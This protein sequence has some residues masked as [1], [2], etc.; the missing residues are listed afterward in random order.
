[1]SRPL[2]P[3]GGF[4]AFEA[5]ARHLSFARA[6]EELRV[7]PAAISHQVRTLEDYLGVALFRRS[8]R[9]VLLTEAGQIMLPDL[10]RSFDLM[11]AAM[12]QAKRLAAGGILTVSMSPSFAA[13]WLMPRIER[14][15]ARHPDID[16]RIDADVRL[17]DFAANEVDIVIRYGPGRYPG[18]DSVLLFEEELFPVCSP[19]LLSGPTPLRSLADLKQQT[20]LHDETINYAG[21]IPSWRMWLQRVG[22]EQAVDLT[23]GLRFT[24]TVTA[25]QAAVDGHG[26]LL[27]RSLIVADDLAAGRLVRPFAESCPAGFGYYLVHPP[28]VAARANLRAFVDWIMEEAR[29]R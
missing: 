28:Q 4:R 14:F 21:P 8:G 23:R 29:G 19:R 11:E 1:M 16:L 6:A 25:T 26:V 12:A 18:L 2:L 20:L 24:A 13:K 10:R 17:V 22:L 7:T 15:R 27:G 5:A 3:L 9:R